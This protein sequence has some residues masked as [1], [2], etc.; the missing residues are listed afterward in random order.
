MAVYQQALEAAA[1]ALQ[2]RPAYWTDYLQ[3]DLHPSCVLTLSGVWRGIG[4]WDGWGP[5]V[6]SSNARET[7]EAAVDKI[8]WWAEQCDHVQGIQV[9]AEDVGGWGSMALNIVTELREQYPG[10]PMLY[11][12]LQ[13]QQT[14]AGQASSIRRD[15]SRPI[16]IAE[17][18]QVAS[19]YVPLSVPV[20]QLKG[21][22]GTALLAA[23]IDTATLCLRC[24]GASTALGSALGSTDM[25]SLV[26]LLTGQGA[27]LASLSLQMPAGQLHRMPNAGDTS[28]SLVLQADVPTCML[29]PG[30]STDPSLSI[31]ESVVLRGA[32]LGSELATTSQCK[33]ALQQYRVQRQSRDSLQ[34]CLTR[35][36]ISPMPVALP[37]YFPAGLQEDHH[38]PRIGRREQWPAPAAMTGLAATAEFQGVLQGSRLRLQSL[39]QAPLGVSC[40]D[41]WGYSASDASELQESIQHLSD[42]Y[43]RGHYND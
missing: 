43:S 29:T 38:Q 36:C 9:L 16:S 26:Q 3:V 18:A 41:Q 12:S 21:S 40:L 4:E 37:V 13:R 17:I 10:V 22:D 35:A 6:D 8:R 2:G 14:D 24:T 32:R 28:S 34:P 39:M 30:I 11:Y 20:E 33:S 23:A 25:H 5:A 7:A 27:N 42:R 31:A 15:L 19:L 1:N